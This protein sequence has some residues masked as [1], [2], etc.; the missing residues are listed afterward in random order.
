MKFNKLYIVASILPLLASC[1]LDREP[2]GLSGLWTSEANV[3]QGLNSAYVPYYEEEAYGRGFLWA[4]GLSDDM[5]YNRTRANEDPLAL[6]S[7]NTNNSSGMADNWTLMYQSIRRASDV[8]KNA[9]NVEMNEGVRNTMLGEANFLC[10]YNY[11]FLAKRYGGLPFF[12]IN[13]PTNSNQPRQTK[14]KTYENIE[15]YLKEAIKY[16]SDVDGEKLWLRSDE[17][18]GKPT[19]G[20]AYGLLAKVYMHWGKFAEAK[21]AAE[22]VIK[23]GKYNLE[24]ANGNGY[25]YL[26]STEGEKSNENLFS[27]INAPIRHQGT[28]TCVVLLSGKLSGG[29]GWYYFAPTRSLYNAFE[30]GD[31]RRLVT[32]RGDGDEF[33]ANGETLILSTTGEAGKGDISDMT[34]GFMCTKYADPYKSMSLSTWEAGADIPLLRYADVLLLH[35]EAIMRLNGAGPDNRTTG[36]AAAAESFN[37]VRVRAFGNDQSKAIAA[38][39]FNDLVRERRCELAYEDERHYDLVRWGMAKEV[40]AAATTDVDPRGPRNFDPVKNEALPLPQSEIDNSNGVLINN[41][42]DGYS[43]FN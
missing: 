31:Q 1:S 34:T 23:S 38:P 41:P 43:N 13:D 15:A 29:S 40:Y 11:F 3:Q 22:E 35:A 20:A 9:P 14:Q 18:Y 25:A 30:E 6:F 12:D 16:F 8:I 28:V 21:A 19:L 5:V 17:D 7:T 39:T 37:K 4:G 27:L 24:T 10:A 36:V 33:V 2:Y 32:L 42:K 26:F